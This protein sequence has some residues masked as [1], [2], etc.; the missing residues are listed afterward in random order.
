MRRL[1][2]KAPAE[3]AYV[4]L[5]FKVPQITSPA[6]T[7]AATVDC[8]RP[9]GAVGRARRLQRRAAGPR[10]DARRAAAWPTAPAPT[11]AWRAVARRLAA[12]TACPPQAKPRR[13]WKPR[14]AQQVAAIAQDGVTE[15]ELNRVKTQWVAGEVYQQDSVFSQ[16]RSLGL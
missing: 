7:D 16:A 15:A 9:D 10:A 12:S 4:S 5:A 2:F 11:A 8:L 13:R 3:Q 14:C 1:D 6:A